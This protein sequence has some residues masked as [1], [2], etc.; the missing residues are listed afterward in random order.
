MASAE[1]DS[2]R[3]DR[4]RFGAVLETRDAKSKAFSATASSS[5][6]ASHLESCRIEGMML[7]VETRHLLLADCF[8]ST[9][10]TKSGKLRHVQASQAWEIAKVSSSK[11]GTPDVL[12]RSCSTE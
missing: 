12:I 9:F 10:A 8:S 6:S 11:A 2:N 1:A 3:L 7:A 4:P 5:K